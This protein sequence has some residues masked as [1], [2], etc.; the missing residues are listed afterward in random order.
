MTE[1]AEQ[2]TELKE[3]TVKNEENLD[4]LTPVSPQQKLIADIVGL[5]NAADPNQSVNAMII[6]FPKCI[7]AGVI[8]LNVQQLD[9]LDNN[10]K[11]VF[12]NSIQSIHQQKR[13]RLL[14]QELISNAKRE[15]LEQLAK[16][17]VQEAINKVPQMEPEVSVD[18]VTYPQNK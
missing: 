6:I 13:S 10:V 18:Q 11:D 16:E 2:L 9:V 15:A 14:A 3:E 4:Q 7:E 1:I 8:N 17:A 5:L 12:A